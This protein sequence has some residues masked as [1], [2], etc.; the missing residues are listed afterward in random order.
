MATTR[1]AKKTT[2]TQ[3]DT[4]KKTP[5]RRSPAKKTPTRRPAA[6]T[7]VPALPKRPRDFMTDG[8]GFA[9]VAARMVGIT[10]HRIRDWRD[11][12]NGTITRPL[13]DGSLLHYDVPTRTLTWQATCPM[14]ATHVYRLHTPSAAAAAR[15]H[16][17][18]CTETHATFT[19]IPRLTEDEL[20]ELGIHTGPTLAKQLPGEPP[21][22][23]IP[24]PIPARPRVLADQLTRARSANADTQPLS[25]ADIDADIDAGLTARADQETP[26][27]HPEP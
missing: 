13:R 17:D 15:I 12:H 11:H 22:E 9:I 21:T 26:K 14:G 4:A 5:A 8:Q 2:P 6:K 16:A 19:H 1:T 3:R 25:R 7:T 27:E 20:T 10:T 18:R 24:V 23:S